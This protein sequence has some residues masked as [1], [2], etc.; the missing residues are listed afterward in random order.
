MNKAMKAKNK[1]ARYPDIFPNSLNTLLFLILFLL[2]SSS[3]PAAVRY[4]RAGYGGGGT[5]WADASG[6]LQAM[7]NA[8]AAGDEVWVAA[9]TYMPNRPINNINTIAAANRL[10]AFLLKDGVKIYGGFV[11]NEISIN[12]RA[13]T[14][15]TYAG[16]TSPITVKRMVNL[17][18]LSGDIGTAGVAT[19]NC[20][21]VVAGAGALSNA[22]VFDGFTV[23]GGYG[24][25]A[26]AVTVNGV[27]FTSYSG[28]GI[29]LIG[30]NTNQPSPV[31]E[32]LV[33][34]A[35]TAY[36]DG[37]GI[38][39]TY[40]PARLTNVQISGNTTSRGYGGGM[41][42]SYNSTAVVFTNGL[43][44]GNMTSTTAT[45]N[46]GGGLCNHSSGSLVLTNVQLSDN[47]TTGQFGGGAILN[48]NGG[49]PPRL[50]LTNVQI[51]NNTASNMGGGIGSQG[52]SLVLTDVQITG[53]TAN[54]GSGGGLYTASGSSY[55]TTLTNVKITGNTATTNGGGIYI[56]YSPT[57]TN[58]IITGNT[59]NGNGGG[60]YIFDFPSQPKLTNVT[61][62][63]NY[64]NTNDGGVHFY[65]LTVQQVRNSIIAGNNSAGSN[66]DVND[67]NHVI[68]SYC[69]VEGVATNAG[70][71]SNANPQ[72]IS[73]VQAGSGSPTTGG[74]YRLQVGSL[75]AN[76]GNNTFFSAGQTP[77]L[78]AIT[79]DLAGN[80]RIKCGTIDLGA[81]ETMTPVAGDI[82]ANGVTIC[83]GEQATLTASSA[84]PY[85]TYRWYANQTTGTILYTGATYQPSPAATT[86]Y[87]V[88][89]SGNNICESETGNR[90]PVTVTVNLRAVAND[91][92]A[93]GAT[94][95]AGEQAT[96]T[97]SSNITN[98]TYRWYADKTTST[99][100]STGATYQ[101][102]PA[103]TTAYYVGVSGTG[104][105]ENI[106]S[107]RKEVTVTVNSIASASDITANDVSISPG[108]T[109]T[110]TASSSIPNATF[111]WY[112]DQALTTVLGTGDTF[113]PLS[114][115]PTS[116]S[117]YVSVVGTGYCENTSGNGKEV[118]VRVNPIAVSGDISINDTSVCYNASV[119]LIASAATV[120]NPEFRW[121]DTQVSPTA[122][123]TTAAG[124]G[125][126]TPALTA[127]RSY[128]VGV[129]GD[130]YRENAAGDRKEVKITILPQSLLNYPDIRI[131]ACPDNNTGINLSKYIDTAEIT[132]LVWQSSQGITLTGGQA[133]IIPA[134]SL[135]AQGTYTF[136]YTVSNRCVSDITRKVY[137]QKLGKSGGMPLSL[138]TISICYEQAEAVNINQIFGIDAAGVWEYYSDVAHDIDAYVTEAPSS[139]DYSGAVIMNG[140][141]IYG[142]STIPYYTYRGN[143]NTKKMEFIYT[144]PA[145]GSCL[146]GKT[147][148]RVI[149]LYE[150]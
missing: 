135:T 10:C 73:L 105:C 106:P 56:V 17:S 64:A 76:I 11:G 98:P 134:G 148:R 117:Y 127:D 84:I 69:L 20:Y 99:V 5:S 8:S 30:N 65:N 120:I 119:T 115:P 149:I 6:D 102:S 60:I 139:S 95:C 32:N 34:S 92:T 131:F 90:K 141:A 63:G 68:Y 88:S 18:V 4:V 45:G 138:D 83:T 78:S 2:V 7:I 31:L 85:P 15:A 35:N 79:T 132:N 72:F 94:V 108:D 140:K 136:T 54:N 121:Y 70:I 103:T 126:A 96:L 12:A 46:G 81:Y 82:T 47:T 25:S 100:L 137:L 109:P 130:N 101:P 67:P 51:F 52:G 44:S 42:N 58:V 33:I 21:H 150:L 145:T 66:K 23:T 3:L 24:A 114:P 128:F 53:N 9:G 50:I 36:N 111:T 41:H 37:G 97:A 61:I 107:N 104:Y 39:T 118:K 142:D 19:D 43:I 71:I 48:K 112:D 110:L 59:A 91:I 93:A 125:F 124:E 75:A 143:A 74:N 122:L 77:D 129:S 57:L 13:T 1:H 14:T 87:Y 40:S 147:Y 55:T 123:D 62:A 49:Y 146:S 116:R 86:T 16:V 133:G 113:T 29:C 27:S 26:N 144:P 22:T 89:V 38:S 28:G 80:P